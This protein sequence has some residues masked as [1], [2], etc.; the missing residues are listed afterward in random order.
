MVYEMNE[1]L[2]DILVD[3]V[4]EIHSRIQRLASV[5]PEDVLRF[6]KLEPSVPIDVSLGM[7][8][9]NLFEKDGRIHQPRK[10]TKTPNGS[11]NIFNAYDISF[12]DPDEAVQN[13]VAGLKSNFSK[14]IYSP[15]E[16][17]FDG[18]LLETRLN[19]YNPNHI[20]QPYEVFKDGFNRLS[21]QN[22]LEPLF[23]VTEHLHMSFW[24]NG[25]SLIADSYEESP[26]SFFAASG[27]LKAQQS[28]P[29]LYVS[30]ERFHHEDPDDYFTIRRFHWGGWKTAR[31]NRYSVLIKSF[32]GD[33][34]KDTQSFHTM[35]NRIGFGGPYQSVV[36]CLSAVEWGLKTYGQSFEETRNYDLALDHTQY[37]DW[38]AEEMGSDSPELA[39]QS[40]A[41]RNSAYP[42]F[43]G[44]AFDD[45]IDLFD[46]YL[47]M[48]HKTIN[49]GMAYDLLTDEVADELIRHVI[50]R[51]D[52]FLETP[53][54]QTI[55]DSE[56][57]TATRAE[58]SQLRGKTSFKPGASQVHLPE[59]YV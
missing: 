9:E 55:F 13:I 56:H 28:L 34:E 58:L 32:E 17:Y 25:K 5:L 57:I 1:H 15:Q 18:A 33:E 20:F 7:E 19:P 2:K 8:F 3:E 16:E 40:L 26:L 30:P 6:Y 21:C 45:R 47:G 35:E 36:L 37:E 43:F 51:Y 11:G 54:A 10:M 50:D 48:I 39:K 24:Q 4:G 27:L 12:G 49:S 52:H 22:N 44:C 53:R 31:Q 23:G 14:S 29:A 59:L 42:N 41:R 46:K 38:M